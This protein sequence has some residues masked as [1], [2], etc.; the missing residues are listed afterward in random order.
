VTQPERLVPRAGE[1]AQSSIE[2]EEPAPAVE[3]SSPR[4]ACGVFGVY[5]PGRPVSHLTYDGLFALQ[6]RGQESAGMAVSDFQ[7][8]TVVKDMGLVA[9]VFDEYKLASLPGSLAV[10]HTRYSTTGSSTWHNAQPVYRQAES[11]SFAVAHN[12]NLTNTEMLAAEL[13]M[14]PGTATSDSDLMAELIVRHLESHPTADLVDALMAVLPRLEG[15]FS[16]VLIDRERLLGVRDRHGF[17]PLCL[18]RID[19]GWVLASETPALDVVGAHFVREVDPGELVVLSRDGLESHQ[20]WPASEIDPRLCLFEFVY[21]ARPDSRLYGQE[22]HSARVRMGEL[23]ADQSPASADLVIGVPDSGV[24]AAEGYA[25]RT[26][27]PFGHGLVKNRYIGRTFIH[28]DQRARAEG[29]RRKLNPLRDTIAGKRLVVVDDSIVRGTTTRAMVRMLRDAGAAEVHL[30]ISSPPYRWPCYFGLDTGTRGELIAANLSVG[31]VRDYV[32][33]DSLA[34]LTLE[35]LEL[36]T[37]A[38][39]AGFCHACLTGEYPVE[40]PLSLSKSVLEAAGSL[41]PAESLD[42]HG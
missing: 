37:G 40:V 34:Y 26:G 18:G 21:L 8:M 1:S 35:A 11:T 27:I 41:D 14:L 2:T 28:P 3:H 19:D 24:P 5:A 36:A 7:R 25:R 20:P 4:E 6:H 10:G 15:A 39:G 9:S 29:V 32:G 17:R 42:A 30:R 12:G 13:G 33:A 16:L 38:P 31:E 22:L 23:L